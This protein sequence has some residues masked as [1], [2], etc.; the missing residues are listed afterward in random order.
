MKPGT[1]AGAGTPAEMQPGTRAGAFAEM[2]PETG[3]G[4]PSASSSG[5]PGWSMVEGTAAAM[6]SEGF[7]T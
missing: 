2:Q 6:L 5:A 3:A 1:G 4:A 7:P